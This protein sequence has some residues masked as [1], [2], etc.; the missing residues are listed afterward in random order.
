MAD[1]WDLSAYGQYAQTPPKGWTSGTNPTGQKGYTSPSGNVRFDYVRDDPWKVALGEA[2][3]AGTTAGAGAPPTWPTTIPT[4]TTSGGGS[5]YGGGG[6]APVDYGAFGGWAYQARPQGLDY[7]ALSLP[8]YRQVA[9]RAWDTS[10][11]DQAR[12]GVAGGIADAR[13]M[14]NTAFDRQL[15]EYQA[16]R[17]PYLQGPR[18]SNPGVDPRLLRSMEAWGGAGS[19]GAAQAYNEGVQADQAMRSVYDLLASGQDQYQQ[20]LMRSTAGDR[21]QLDQRLGAEQRMLDLGINMAQAR[22]KQEY[23]KEVWQLGKEAADINYATR[24][25]QA[26]SN[27]QRQNTVADTN[28]ATGNAWNQNMLNTIL[29]MIQSGGKNIPQSGNDLSGLIMAPTSLYQR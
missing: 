19:G 16:M 18:T 3:R 26:M 13:D 14:G 21:M 6:S 7:T 15:A 1:N 12:S 20:G 28:V 27:W 17:N 22:A 5:R 4:T 29:S 10:M 23:D 8:E 24:M 25:Q 11:Y 9:P 2:S